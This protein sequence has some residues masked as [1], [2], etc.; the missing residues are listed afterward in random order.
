MNGDV[1]D[2]YVRHPLGLPPTPAVYAD[3]VDASHLLYGAVYDL[4]IRQPSVE[5]VVV[6]LL[7]NEAER[8]STDPAATAAGYVVR[9]PSAA[10]LSTLPVL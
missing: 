1:Y 6:L 4:A 9:Q 8:V 10:P 2:L 5:S 7:L 3:W